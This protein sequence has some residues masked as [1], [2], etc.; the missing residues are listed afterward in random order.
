[1]SP[2][3]PFAVG[4]VTLHVQS[5]VYRNE[6]AALARAFESLDRAVDFAIAGRLISAVSMTYGD[7]S[8]VSVVDE[9]FLKRLTDS[10]T[11][12]S[13]VRKIFFGENIGT[14]RGHNKLAN[15]SGAMLTL[16]MNPDVILAPN[17]LIELVRPFQR[18]GV[19]MTE[20]RQVPI[21]HPKEY[22]TTTGETSWASTAA[23]VIP[24]AL[25][26][27]LDGFDAD[28]FFLY[29]DDV[30]FSWRVRL[31]GY[32]IIFQPSA[33]VFHD[34]RLSIFGGWMPSGAEKYYSA[35]A[36]LLM[37]QKWSRPDLVERYLSDFTASQES[38]HHR[39]T[40]EFLRRRS[41]NLLPAALDPNH[42]IST[43]VNGNYTRHRF[44]LLKSEVS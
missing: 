22:D 33:A 4:P 32:K 6:H 37:A 5:I 25:L 35:E 40:A 24:T 43:F 30:D 8:P 2:E 14:A 44:E 29:C 34:K 12:I 41:A 1:M 11:A 31:A 9:A 15:G 21:E 20:A 28:T 23:A 18:A 39:A 42:K 16:V 19:G 10:A 3:E 7:C 13:E 27:A 17:A 38:E 26:H 36:A